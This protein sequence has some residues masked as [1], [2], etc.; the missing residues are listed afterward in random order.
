MTSIGYQNPISS[1]CGSTPGFNMLKGLG[2][3][4]V[5]GGAIRGYIAPQVGDTN[6]DNAYAQTR[7]TLRDSWNTHY[8]NELGNKKRIVTPFRAV[9]NSGDVLCRKN[10]SCGGPTQTFQSRPGLSGLRGRFGAIQSRCDDS[11]VPAAACNGKFVYD[12][13]DYVTYL[14]QRAVNR[15]YNDYSNGGNDNSGSQSAYRAIRRY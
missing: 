7:F 2:G 15:N 1:G 10:Y 3:R 11:G 4:P 13:S 9:T 5:R 14:K 12:S 8:V 6:N